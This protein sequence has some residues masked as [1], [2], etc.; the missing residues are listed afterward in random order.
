[1]VKRRKREATV[2]C[3]NAE[4]KRMLAGDLS[5]AAD[6]AY[7]V[8]QAASKLGLSELAIELYRVMEQLKGVILANSRL[9]QAV[10]DILAKNAFESLV[11]EPHRHLLAL[12][13]ATLFML[14]LHGF[15]AYATGEPGWASTERL[16]R[17]AVGACAELYLR[18][19]EPQ[20]GELN[21]AVVKLAALVAEQVP[22]ARRVWLLELPC[23]NSIPVK[24]LASQL[25]SLG[26]ETETIFVALHRNDSVRKGVTRRDLL[27]ERLEKAE[28]ARGD[29]V[30]YVDEW[31]SGSNFNTVSEIVVR[32]GAALG[33]VVLPAALIAPT[34][35]RA[36]RFGSFARAHDKHCH[37]LAIDPERLR[38]DFS[39][40][41]RGED[42]CDPRPFFWAEHDRVAGYRKTQLNGTQYQAWY[43]AMQVL[44]NDIKALE[45]CVSRLVLTGGIST[46]DY[47][48]LDRL[49]ASGALHAAYMEWVSRL[50]EWWLHVSSL[51]GPGQCDGDDGIEACM[52]DFVS[53]FGRSLKAYGLENAARVAAVWVQEEG[54]NAGHPYAIDAQMPVIV[55]LEG[56]LAELHESIMALLL[57]WQVVAD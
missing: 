46:Q 50:D 27:T 8:I 18:F 21:C 14:V 32:K 42:W 26:I 9:L 45:R 5:R 19:V 57:S 17:G 40:M 31:V 13:H 25:R 54:H 56:Y 36:E 55:R 41:P 7:R 2:R 10:E 6:A 34:A 4:R 33:F 52:D 47:H 1:M 44:S 38:F 20:P 16:L 43:T 30:V 28:V 12:N 51:P 39:A 35:R 22:Q 48:R 53:Q 3:P 15:G 37:R 49:G 11:S 24:L 23:G 29:V